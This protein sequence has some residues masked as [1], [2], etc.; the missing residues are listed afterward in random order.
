MAADLTGVTEMTAFAIR[1]SDRRL[2][3]LLDVVDRT[4]PGRTPLIVAG[5][6]WRR[7]M[8]YLPEATA[9]EVVNGR[10]LGIGR[11]TD[12]SAI[13][14]SGEELQT[15]CPV[16]WLASGEGADG[17]SRPADVTETVPHV[18]WGDGAWHAVGQLGRSASCALRAPSRLTMEG[19]GGPW[20]RFGSLALSPR[21]R[22]EKRK[23]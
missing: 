5:V 13:T 3:S 4:C 18:G 9:I 11:H 6:D 20:R 19:H 10:V 22:R 16:I 17:V 15:S 7:V 21:A 1:Q 23:V 12:A 14:P 8:W 2:Q